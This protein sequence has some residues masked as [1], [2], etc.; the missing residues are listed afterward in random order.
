MNGLHP[1]FDSLHKLG[2]P[3]RGKIAFA[4]AARAQQREG[5][6]VPLKCM[7]QLVS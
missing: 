2:Q 5:V 7:P 6:G 4:F 3:L 1:R